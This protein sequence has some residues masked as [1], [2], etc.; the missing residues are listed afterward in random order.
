M[1]L[2]RYRPKGN[3]TPVLDPVL[4]HLSWDGVYDN[5]ACATDPRFEEIK[6]ERGETGSDDTAAKKAPGAGKAGRSNA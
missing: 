5:E 3:R 4:G 6:E 2:Y 1:A